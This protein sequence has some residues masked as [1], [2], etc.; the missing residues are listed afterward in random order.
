MSVI[1]DMVD[2]IN[3][4]IAETTEQRNSLL[5]EVNGT[6]E[7]NLNSNLASLEEMKTSFDQAEAERAQEYAAELKS[8]EA[9]MKAICDAFVEDGNEEAWD[10]I[11]GAY[12]EI[13]A[14]DTEQDAGILAFGEEEKA[15]LE[16]LIAS[17]GTS[18]DVT[19]VFEGN[20]A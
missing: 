12:A 19:E 4:R 2:V 11:A 7:E 16:N 10:D 20:E 8:T 14:I 18:D 5:D 15:N 6:H 3:A 17:I 13:V 1:K 9:E